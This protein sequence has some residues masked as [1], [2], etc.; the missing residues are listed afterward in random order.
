MRAVA[1][2]AGVWGKNSVA[3]SQIE[4]K[5]LVLRFFPLLLHTRKSSEWEAD[6]VQ[7][8]GHQEGF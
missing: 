7:N 2:H 3:A 4:N 8:A 5:C 1:P 6:G